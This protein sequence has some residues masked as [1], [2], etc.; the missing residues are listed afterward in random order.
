MLTQHP[1]AQRYLI[2]ALSEAPDLF[3]HLLEGL[4][5]E[6]ADFRPDPKR[7]TIREIMAHLAEW[8]PIFLERMQ[9]T[10]AED[11]PILPNLDEGELAAQH[12]YAASD[13]NEQCRLF[14]ERRARLVDFLRARTVEDWERTANRPEIGI[15]TLEAL[16][17]L[18][19]LHDTYHLAQITK[20][21]QQAAK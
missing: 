1:Y 14:R 19:P 4:T 16:A 9:R 11:Q 3:D 17:L 6:E 15:V 5:L 21:R 2:T 12:N 20:W 18:I 13:V 8:E 10:C 7:F